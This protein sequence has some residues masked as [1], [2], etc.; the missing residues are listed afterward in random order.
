[1]VGWLVSKT[2]GF[3]PHVALSARREQ[4]G[5]E[6]MGTICEG[7]ALRE[8]MPAKQRRSVRTGWQGGGGGQ[9]PSMSFTDDET[10][11]APKQ[12]WPGLKSPI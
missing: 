5:R 12:A 7:Q 4:Q 10:D 2:N 6:S 9:L 8:L 3:Q 1:M 11:P